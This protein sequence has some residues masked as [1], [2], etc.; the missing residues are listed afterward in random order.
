MKAAK[1]Y[2]KDINRQNAEYN[3]N[4]L[5]NAFSQSKPEILG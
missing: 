3:K 4:V 5:K 1:K 2:T